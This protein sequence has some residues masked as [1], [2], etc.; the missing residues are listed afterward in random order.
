M[1]FGEGVG[2]AASDEVDGEGGWG[3]L[4]LGFG[5][6]YILIDYGSV[7]VKV[8]YNKIKLIIT[9]VVRFLIL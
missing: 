4:E 2:I 6:H 3:I 1:G 8:G 7:Y 5:I 9:E